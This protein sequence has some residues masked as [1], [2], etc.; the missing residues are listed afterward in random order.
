MEWRLLEGV[1]AE[2][3]RQLLSVARR[4]TFRKGEVVFHRGDP[5][6]SLH[7][8]S[9]GRFKVQVRRR[10]ASR[11]RSRSAGRATRSA[12]W[13]SSADGREAIGDDRGLEEAETFCVIEASSA[14]CAGSIQASIGC[15]I[16]FLANE[17]RMLNERLLEALYVPVEKRVLRRLAELAELYGSGDGRGRHPA[18][19]GGACRPCRHDARDRQPDTPRRAGERNTRARSRQDDRVGPGGTRLARSLAQHTKRAARRPPVR[20]WRCAAAVYYMS[21]FA[22]EGHRARTRRRGSSTVMTMTFRRVRCLR[23]IG[24]SLEVVIDCMAPL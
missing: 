20:R 2:E 12:R 17:V 24:A 18:D 11:R 5:A 1:P 21:F 16:D 19:A 8:I 23:N 6:D 22:G 9:K 15:V 3:V 7:L 14:G 13:R 4:R 10:S